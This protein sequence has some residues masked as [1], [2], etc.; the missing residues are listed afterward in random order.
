[1]VLTH[2]SAAYAGPRARDRSPVR[3]TSSTSAVL[4]GRLACNVA[5]V[6]AEH[7]GPVRVAELAGP[8]D[9]VRGGAERLEVRELGLSLA[10]GCGRVF[11]VDGR[12]HGPGR[13]GTRPP[14]ATW[15]E[16]ST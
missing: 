11:L 5:R 9:L 13:V 10:V 8:L 7:L 6:P 16:L 14:V 2:E 3:W 1:M 15:F 4:R 12:E